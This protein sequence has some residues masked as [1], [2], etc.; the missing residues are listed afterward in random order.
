MTHLESA[1]QSSGYSRPLRPMLSD[2][3]TTILDIESLS[4]P[5]PW[6]RG[7]FL[8]CLEHHYCCWVCGPETIVS[9]GIMS[10]VLD[11]AHILNLAVHPLQRQ[12]GFGKQML[13]HLLL[14]AKR[15]KASTAFLEVR[16]S[17]EMALS[18]YRKVG[19]NEIGRRK[20]YYRNQD[21][22]SEDA[23]ILAKTL[24]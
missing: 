20:R 5:F 21:S 15:R 1:N 3:L 13:N 4:H 17:N 23:L 19:F 12:Q 14:L 24:P 16:H 6:T 8:D 22:S 2:D 18:L 9:F 10:T 7:I 11:E